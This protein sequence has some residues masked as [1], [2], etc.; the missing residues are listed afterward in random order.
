MR[1]VGLSASIASTCIVVHFM[2]W[3]G[4]SAFTLVFMFG[5]WSHLGWHPCLDGCLQLCLCSCSGGV[6]SRI[7]GH[8]GCGFMAVVV[9]WGVVLP[10]CQ[11]TC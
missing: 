1:I 3:V 4:V 2:D 11:T 7:G 6:C 9:V 10:E 5:S 8:H